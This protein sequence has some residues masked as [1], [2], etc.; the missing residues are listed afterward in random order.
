EEIQVGMKAVV[1]YNNVEYPAEVYQTS[2]EA[3]QG[4]LSYARLRVNNMPAT[5]KL[6]GQKASFT[7]ELS[8]KEDVYKIYRNLVN[9]SGGRKTVQVLKDD[10]KTVR[11]VVTGFESSSEV[12]IISGLEPGEL[13]IVP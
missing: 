12:E 3:P 4:T 2:R 11:E 13:V 10:I 1:R 5:L 6:N 7:V 9:T 8:R